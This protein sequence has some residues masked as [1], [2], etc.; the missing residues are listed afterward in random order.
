MAVKKQQPAAPLSPRVYSLSQAATVLN[1][2]VWTLR[3]MFRNGQIK[4]VRYNKAS[5]APLMFPVSEIDRIIAE[6]TVTYEP[7]DRAVGALFQDRA[8]AA[9]ATMRKGR[10]AA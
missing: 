10:K 5:N 8:L 7:D 9:R 6:S 2:S 4:A 3:R 1:V